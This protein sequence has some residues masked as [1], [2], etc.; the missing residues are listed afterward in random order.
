MKKIKY[1]AL[2]LISTAILTA[3]TPP[4]TPTPTETA[5]PDIKTPVNDDITANQPFTLSMGESAIFQAGGLTV[6]FNSVVSDS[7]CPSDVVCVWAGE[8]TV[9]IIATTQGPAVEAD[10]VIPSSD[11]DS[12]QLR[13]D[14][15]G[16]YNLKLL[17]LTPHPNSKMGNSDKYQASFIFELAE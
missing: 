11:K 15:G 10:L 13:G 8:A 5:P 3:C 9:H 14:V 2:V 4:I 7:R 16:T 12:I 6:E 17:D 1:L